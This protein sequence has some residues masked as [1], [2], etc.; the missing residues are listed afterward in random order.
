[1][2]ARKRASTV[3]KGAPASQPYW[4]VPAN[5]ACLNTTLLALLLIAWAQRIAF[6]GELASAE[7]HTFCTRILHIAGQTASRARQLILHLDA[8]WS[9]TNQAVAGYQRIRHAFELT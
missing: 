2:S 1:L 3:L 6:D 4:D 9:W 8:Q 5:E 7:P